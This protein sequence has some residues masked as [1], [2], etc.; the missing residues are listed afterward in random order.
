MSADLVIGDQMGQATLESCAEADAL[1]P[2][3]A[4]IMPEA[5]RRRATSDHDMMVANGFTL[6]PHTAFWRHDATGWECSS[7]EVGVNGA[8]A[9][10]ERRL[11]ALRGI[12][13]VNQAQVTMA[14]IANF[15]VSEGYNVA[16]AQGMVY[17][18]SPPLPWVNEHMLN[19]MERLM[20]KS[21][22]KEPKR[23]Q[24]ANPRLCATWCGLPFGDSR[25]DAS[26]AFSATKEF[27]LESPAYCCPQRPEDMGP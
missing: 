3:V 15:I 13:A 11:R 4:S 12:E 8:A 7:E 19:A 6:D 22:R 25:V 23:A 26:I 20:E 1:A 21:G 16:T 5:K 18:Q 17:R 27:T 9:T 2:N 24:S 14:S 10:V